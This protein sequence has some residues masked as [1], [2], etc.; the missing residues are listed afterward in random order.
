MERSRR[1]E[2]ERLE[3]WFTR[4]PWTTVKCEIQVLGIAQGVTRQTKDN[5]MNKN[6]TYVA[7][8]DILGLTADEDDVILRKMGVEQT[9]ARDIYLHVAAPL[10]GGAGLRVIELWDN[11]E[12]FETFIQQ[13]MLPVAEAL[14]VQRETKVTLTPLLNAFVPRLQDMAAMPQTRKGSESAR[15][16]RRWVKLIK[17][18]F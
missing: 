17:S 15:Y 2:P 11:K 8:I 16:T 12:G 3:K 14:G 9:P 13:R 1:C 7:V 4:K 10:D 18:I 6:T 5:T